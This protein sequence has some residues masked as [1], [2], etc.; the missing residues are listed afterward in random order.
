MNALDFLTPEEHERLEHGIQ[1]GTLPELDAEL[2][3]GWNLKV[4]LC[5]AE[6]TT[7]ARAAQTIEIAHH[8]AL[9]QLEMIVPPW[10]ASWTRARHGQEC[11]NDPGFQR[12]FLRDNP[13]FGIRSRTTKTTILH[14][15]FSPE[16]ANA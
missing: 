9:G 15:G 11:F 8:E 7:M 16:P 2:R 1:R 4:N 13:E 3:R 14:P 5:A 6:A 12:D 10:A